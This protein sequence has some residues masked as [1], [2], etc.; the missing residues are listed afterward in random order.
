MTMLSV[1]FEF[2]QI[3]SEPRFVELVRKLGLPQ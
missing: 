2:D 1:T 3:R